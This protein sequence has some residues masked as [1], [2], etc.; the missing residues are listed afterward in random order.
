MARSLL[1][2]PSSQPIALD[3]RTAAGTYLLHASI[4]IRS[5]APSNNQTRAQAERLNQAPENRIEQS[6]ER[7]GCLRTETGEHMPLN[8]RKT[9]TPFAFLARP[10][11]GA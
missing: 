9:C 7:L 2:G 1:L 8:G 4:Q 3:N 10:E 11:C 5:N 6:D